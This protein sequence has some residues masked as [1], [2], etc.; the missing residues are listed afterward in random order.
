[1]RSTL[2]LSYQN[3]CL[4]LIKS[5]SPLLLIL[6]FPYL[7]N[8]LFSIISF[9]FSFFSSFFIPLPSSSPYS[10]THIPFPAY[11]IA[12]LFPFPYPPFSV[13]SPIP[14]YYRPD[15]YPLYSPIFSLFP[16]PLSLPHL[17]AHRSL[18]LCQGTPIQTIH[19]LAIQWLQ[20]ADCNIP[21]TMI[22]PLGDVSS[23]P[24]QSTILDSLFTEG[25]DPLFTKALPPNLQM[26]QETQNALSSFMLV[27]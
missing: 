19:R 13:P 11:S 7:L 20:A 14:P 18:C 9:Y 25:G 6:P 10:L 15:P 8:S 4:N 22:T 24:T 1:M 16:F 23:M 26:V 12:L 2:I 17:I 5:P 3:R 27:V 21:P